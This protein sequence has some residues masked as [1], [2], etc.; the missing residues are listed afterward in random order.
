MNTEEYIQVVR[1]SFKV[2]K[3]INDLENIL[4]YLDEVRKRHIKLQNQL[5]LCL[6]DPY[7]YETLEFKEKIIA[8]AKDIKETCIVAGIKYVFFKL[9]N[10]WIDFS[11]EYTKTRSFTT[12][13]YNSIDITDLI[14]FTKKK[15]QKINRIK[16][17]TTEIIDDESISLAELAFS[18]EEKANLG[19]S[20][21]KDGNDLPG[22]L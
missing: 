13:N 19:D 10:T 14:I 7:T 18:N 6:I 3:Y 2:A 11:H 20:F 15:K 1:A 5:E 4:P 16:G 12:Y 17:A 9:P 21:I 8:I 22:G